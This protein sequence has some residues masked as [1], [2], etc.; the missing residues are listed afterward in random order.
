V[1]AK[2]VDHICIAVKDLES[3]RKA[4][5]DTLGLEPAQEY[6]SL[7]EKIKVVRYYLGEVALELMEDTDGTGDVAKFI[8]KRGEGVF[9][10]SYRVDDVEAG[11][12]ELRGKG[13]KTIDSEPREMMGI[14]YAFVQPPARLG[15]VLTE[16]MDGRWDPE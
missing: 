11:L 14:R 7:S 5:E 2:A 16:I 9:L 4:Y 6:V 10:V 15:G 1:K 12:K 13:Q 3:A 8:N